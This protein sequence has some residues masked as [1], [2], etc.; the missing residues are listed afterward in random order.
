MSNATGYPTEGEIVALDEHYWRCERG[1]GLV[2]ELA[3]FE[4]PTDG[5]YDDGRRLGAP[6]VFAPG[7]LAFATAAEDGKELSITPPTAS[8]SFLGDGTLPARIRIEYDAGELAAL[9][10]QGIRRIRWKAFCPYDG[11]PRRRLEG[12]IDMDGRGE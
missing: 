7:S 2:Y 11:Q 6:E 12:V 8:L 5:N 3:L 4:S 10:D 1:E 9:F